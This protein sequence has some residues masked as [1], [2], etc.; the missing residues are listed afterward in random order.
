MRYW[1]CYLIL[2][3]AC[4]KPTDEIHFK[5]SQIECVEWTQDYI[6]KCTLFSC[7]TVYMEHICETWEVRGGKLIYPEE[8]TK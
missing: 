5:G 2:L 6:E 7:S 1:W 3:T 8:D 4:S